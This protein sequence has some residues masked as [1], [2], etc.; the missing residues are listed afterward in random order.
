VVQQGLPF[1][2]ASMVT[3]NR[4]QRVE[5]SEGRLA[6]LRRHLT[7]RP[8][9]WRRRGRRIWTRSGSRVGRDQRAIG[10]PHE[11]AGHAPVAVHERLDCES[12]VLDLLSIDQALTRLGFVVAN[13]PVWA[14]V[15]GTAADGSV[16]IAVLA[17][18]TALTAHNPQAR[19]S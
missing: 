2:V 14:K 4:E 13:R 9:L 10:Q 7:Q 17:A 11:A 1:S 12:S 3:Y 16:T 6:I 8:M 19:L 18:P 15:A 5:S